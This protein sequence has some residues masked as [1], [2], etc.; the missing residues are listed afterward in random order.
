MLYPPIIKSSLPAFNYKNS[1]RIYF[2][3]STYNSLSDIAQA[4]VTVKYQ[5]NNRNAMN[6]TRYPNK[7]KCCAITQV[8][9][10][11]DQAVAATLAHYYIELSPDDLVDGYFDPSLIYKVQLRFS[12]RSW[13]SSSSAANLASTSSEWSTVCLIKPI[14]IPKFYILQLGGS[15][16]SEQTGESDNVAIVYSSIEP[17]FTG[18]YVPVNA[19]ESLKSWRMRLYD[20]SEVNLLADSG[21]NQVNAYESDGGRLTFECELPYVMSNNSLYHL[22]FDIETKNGYTQTREYNFTA[23]A[24]A[25]GTINAILTA[26]VNEEDGYAAVSLASS[27][28]IMHTNVTVRRTS[29]KSNFTIWQDIANKTF[30]NS[31]LNWEFDDFTIESGVF[32]QYSA[33]TRD[34][35]GRRSVSVKSNTIM[36]EFDDA[37][38]TEKGGSL[39]DALQ[40]KIR[41]DMNI[42]NSVI[43]VGEAKTDTIGSQYPF[44]RRNGNMY[45]RSFPFSFLIACETDNNHLFTTERILRD[46]QVDL[47]KTTYSDHSLTVESGRYDYTYQREFRRKV[48]Q[49]L[50]NNKVKLFRS[51]T[52]GNILVKLM[53]ITLTPKAE[54]GRLLYS[55]D[56]TAYEIDAPTLKNI[57]AY[58][59]QQIGT[60]NPN[61]V[62]NQIKIGQLNRFRNEWDSDGNLDVVE[63]YYPANFNLM[64]QTGTQGAIP[65]IK[66]IFHWG[67]SI[68][69]VIISDLYLSY[70][71]IQ[72]DSPPYLI[73]NEGGVLTPLDDEAPTTDIVDEDTLL[74]TL[75]DIGGTT[76]MIQYPNNVYQMK[77]DTVYIS[78]STNITPL[79]ATQMTVDFIANLSEENDNT[80]IATTLI[81]K[82]ITG[83]LIDTFNSEESLTTLINRKYYLDLYQSKNVDSPYYVKVQVIYNLHI[84]ADPG[85]VLYVSSNGNTEVQRLVLDETGVLFI[86]PGI[87]EGYITEAYFYGR[88]I[89]KRWT[90]DRGGAAPSDPHQY[91]RYTDSTGTYIYFNGDWYLGTQM[92]NASSYDIAIEVP[93]IVEYYIQ[94]QTG[95]Y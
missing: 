76:I 68:N 18:V 24:S 13:S 69:D 29:S 21:T 16:L 11:Q 67:E 25:S 65:T 15:S 63:D 86:D 79:K 5:K 22:K 94:S 39:S 74:G 1:V 31:A 91:D 78:S 2:A 46:N 93:A 87:D 4:Q 75:I 43:N 34:N 30:E 47:Y 56:A 38:L 83:Q 42:T 33:Q 7:I 23:M 53:G 64:G 48:E 70:L 66:S 77:G 51:L 54:L 52:E 95:I 88:N 26:S 82:S 20:Q 6:T 81:Y 92:D 89:Q 36:G 32:Y 61:I 44:I 3:I 49:F 19:K 27:A 37:F 17:V 72:I 90:T 14:E 41:Y 84:Q 10:Q 8:T 28:G 60:Y 35:R 73:K 55:V 71:R 12:S 9:A 57:D 58:G 62:F 40:L 80:V 50:Y 85:T 59:I 45:Y